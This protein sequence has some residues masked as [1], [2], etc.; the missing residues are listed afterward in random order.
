MKRILILPVLL[1][2][3]LLCGA[4]G[5]TQVSESSSEPSTSEEAVTHEATEKIVF[6][7]DT[8]RCVEY[9]EYWNDPESAHPVMIVTHHTYNKKTNKELSLQEV[10]GKAT[11]ELAD[12]IRMLLKQNYPSLYQHFWGD[13]NAMSGYYYKY[14]ETLDI[15]KLDFSI[16]EDGRIEVYDSWGLDNATNPDGL[17]VYVTLESVRL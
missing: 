12:E 11:G 3:V 6:E 2:V 16:T 17:S 10:S 15:G 4:C 14:F 5:Q 1:A 7:N 8:I 9:F 13:E